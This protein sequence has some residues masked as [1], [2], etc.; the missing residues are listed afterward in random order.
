MLEDKL[1][2]ITAMMSIFSRHMA[3]SHLQPTDARKVFP[4]FDEP[5]LKATFSTTMERKE[6]WQSYSNTI[7]ASSDKM[8]VT[9]ENSEV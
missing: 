4:C 9:A 3:T 7:I 6:N 1:K 5:A 2:K 8:L